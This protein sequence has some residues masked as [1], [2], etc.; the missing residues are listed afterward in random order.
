MSSLPAF[1]SSSL[2]PPA[3]APWSM[4]RLLAA[5]L[6]LLLFVASVIWLNLSASRAVATQSAALAERRIPE[7]RAISDLRAQLAAR[8]NQLYL[9]Y[10]TTEGET[11][12]AA[13]RQIE[14][15]MERC[16]S[17][18]ISLGL[19]DDEQQR[20]RRHAGD[21][22]QHT[23]AF[24]REMQSPARRSWDALREHLAAA[25][26]SLDAQAMMFAAWD[27]AIRLTTAEASQSALDEVGRLT[28]LQIAFSLGVL[29]VA[30]VTMLVLRARQKDQARLHQQAYFDQLTGLPNR[31]SLE[32]ALQHR[33]AD[34][35]GCLLLLSLPAYQR[36]AGAYGQA[37]ADALLQTATLWLRGELG[38][39][40]QRQLL[41]R[42]EG[43]RL[44]VL[45]PGLGTT[46]EA[47]AL[48]ARLRQIADYPLQL[49]GRRVN[50]E[51]RIGITL[52]P[53]DGLDPTCLIRNADAALQHTVNG[54]HCHFFSPALAT[55]NDRRLAL[56]AALR[57][58]L[59]QHELS[60]HY[61]PKVTPAGALRG[62][63]ALARW[64][65]D[66]QWVSPGEFIPVAEESGL[67]IPLGN[68]VVEEACRQWQE[69]QSSG[70]PA[71]PLAV[72]IS[73]QQF[74]APDFP[75][76]LAGTLA[77]HRVPPAMLELEITEAV[78]ANDPDKVIATMHKLKKLGVSLA[79]DDF[80]TGYSSLTY[81][82]R[83]PIDTLKIDQSFIR[84]HHSQPAIVRLILALAA[85]LRLQVVAEGV[86]TSEQQT[87][88]AALGCDLLQGYHFSRPLPPVAYAA[89]LASEPLSKG[90]GANTNVLQ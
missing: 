8:G 26:R 2:L 41:F 12:Q 83:F 34:S 64:Q 79:I 21:W 42:I 70:L 85:E 87:M 67:I 3:R 11:W 13:D 6:L 22:Q 68:W 89:W 80:G 37:S 75:D 60:L 43:E 14:Q 81:L 1:P 59:Q 35:D 66:G 18:L 56:E 38:W 31:R 57:Q 4:R 77:D 73:A 45:A 44:A 32:Y 39:L 90:S 9:Y 23:Q 47:A 17:A 46:A 7:L 48:A 49:E 84:D 86:E 72:N 69:W 52:Y 24:T 61:Q 76:W 10:A 15:Q 62:A 19:P 36:L 51:L 16:L 29:L 65:R 53:G 71:L 27:E 28:R 25:Q 30:G 33:P 58:A 55:A 50:V 88:L 5:F 78:A 20:Y 54:D 63:E 82:Q 40:G 74:Q